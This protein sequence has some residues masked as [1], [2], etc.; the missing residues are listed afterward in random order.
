MVVLAL[1]PPAMAQFD[2]GCWQDTI[3]SNL[4]MDLDVGDDGSI[5]ETL[6]FAQ[7]IEVIR[8]EPLTNN[9]GFRTIPMQVVSWT[10]SV[11]SDLLSA[12]IAL[13]SSPGVPQPLG[14][15]V[16]E[17]QE[18]DYPATVTY[19]VIYDVEFG[20]ETI[21]SEQLGT[22]TG[23][24]LME[25]PPTAGAVF[26]VGKDILITDPLL[27]RLIPLCLHRRLF[28]Q[29]MCEPGAW[30]LHRNRMYNRSRL[31]F[32]S[33]DPASAG[34]LI[35]AQSFWPIFTKCPICRRPERT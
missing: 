11:H 23:A 8:F 19:K 24:G 16:A 21:L 1:T 20:G 15:T 3:T 35:K 13:F 30:R 10:S 7:T 22:A 33:R 27:I 9:D 29:Y 34:T 12:D 17:Q 14:S 31:A 6:V 25:V 18:S 4:T 5:E 2:D 26:T 32:A 28:G